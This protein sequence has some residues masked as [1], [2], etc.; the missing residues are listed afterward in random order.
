MLN[1][2]LSATDDLSAVKLSLEHS[3]VAL[4]KWEAIHEKPFFG[5]E[6]K[7]LEETKS[8]ITQMLLN[9]DYPVNFFDRLTETQFKAIGDYI[10]SKQTATTFGIELNEKPSSETITAELI[11]YWLAQFQIPFW[12]TETWHLNRLMTL[13]KVVG[14]KQAKP[15]KMNKNELA[16]HYRKLN[17]QRKLESGSAG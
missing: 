4:S 7:D 5:R 16:E 12:P 1:I 15:K 2:V 11:Y 10:N 3:L 8:Y 17:E 13:V 14:V 6:D 9:D